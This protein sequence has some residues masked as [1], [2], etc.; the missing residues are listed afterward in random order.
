MEIIDIINISDIASR[1]PFAPNA[2]A[3]RSLYSQGF[4]GSYKMGKEGKVKVFAVSG[5]QEFTTRA[6]E[7][8]ECLQVFAQCFGSVS[9]PTGAVLMPSTGVM[10]TMAISRQLSR[11]V[12]NT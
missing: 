5:R 11:R 12:Q 9:R 7:N 8:L 6:V 3:L 2:G 1:F 10:G 4:T